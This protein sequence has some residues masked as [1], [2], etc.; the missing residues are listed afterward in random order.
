MTISTSQHNNI[1]S[2][3]ENY[4]DQIEWKWIE[5]RNVRCHVCCCF[6]SPW[7]T[8]FDEYP[9]EIR[10]PNCFLLFL[11]SIPWAEWW[12]PEGHCP[13]SWIPH[14]SLKRLSATQ[15]RR[16]HGPL[17]QLPTMKNKT[18][19][20]TKQ[21]KTP[22]SGL[23][24]ISHHANQSNLINDCGGLFKLSGEIPQYVLVFHLLCII[25]Y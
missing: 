2:R 3:L 5:W 14:A 8:W 25:M 9:T 12:I 20:T 23:A 18:K 10:G 1:N 11:I 24:E 21:T 6:G 4:A 15:R 13:S 17:P 19:Q 7:A 22:Q 16:T